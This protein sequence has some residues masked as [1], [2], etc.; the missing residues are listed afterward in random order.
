MFKLK[1]SETYF[2]PV[3]VEIVEDGGKVAKSTFDAEFKRL[4]RK[5]VEET[6]KK[7]REGEMNDYEVA[8]E[9]FVGWKGVVDQHGEPLP[10]SETNRD[11]VL[12]IHPTLPTLVKAWGASLKGAKTKN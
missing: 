2:Y 1:T 11:A 7:I 9:V 10:F 8:C 5:D 3:A 12:E 6:M 4:P